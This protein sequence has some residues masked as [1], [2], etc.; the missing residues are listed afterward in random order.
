MPYR[1]LYNR[2]GDIR[3][4]GGLWAYSPWRRRRRRGEAGRG[5]DPGCAHGAVAI[6]TPASPPGTL[7]H[8]GNCLGPDH[9]R[10]RSTGRA[11]LDPPLLPRSSLSLIHISE[12]TRLGM[13]SYA[14]F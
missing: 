11:A 14:V 5:R 6:G 8:P 13:I 1:L 9:S 10:A 12:P 4:R 3:L 2:A 7:V